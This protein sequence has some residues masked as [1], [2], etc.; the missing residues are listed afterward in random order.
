MSDGSAVEM[1]LQIVQ[2]FPELRLYLLQKA[3]FQTF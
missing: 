2:S 3:V 1:P